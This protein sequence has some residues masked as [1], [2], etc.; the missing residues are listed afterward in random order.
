[1]VDYGV[2]VC[3]DVVRLYWFVDESM[4]RIVDVKFKSF[5]CGIVIV[6]LDMMVELC[7]NKRV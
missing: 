2:E 5:G 4:D 3:G 6:S 7:L 1:M